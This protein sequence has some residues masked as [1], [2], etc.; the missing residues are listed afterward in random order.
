[1][2]PVLDQVSIRPDGISE[3]FRSVSIRRGGVGHVPQSRLWSMGRLGLN[4]Q[5]IQVKVFLAA[6]RPVAEI[7]YQISTKP[8]DI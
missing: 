6:R 7:L 5:P 2:H 4:Q 3:D 8:A 1:M